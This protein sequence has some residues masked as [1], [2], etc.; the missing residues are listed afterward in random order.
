MNRIRTSVATT[1]SIATLA[2]SALS[3]GSAAADTT[4]L[5]PLEINPVCADAITSL[6]YW[7]V[8]NKNDSSVT[9]DWTAIDNGHTGSFSAVTGNSQFA[10]YYDA[11]D[12]NN[13]T[14]F[15]SEIT[16]DVQR[17]SSNTACQPG[18]IT[19]TTTPDNGSGSIGTDNGSG[20]I[21][22]DNGSGSTAPDNGSGSTRQDNGSGSTG[23]K[24]SG[25]IGNDS[26]NGS[27]APEIGSGSTALVGGMGGG[28]VASTPTQAV[29][30]TPAVSAP[31][32]AYTGAS[33]ILPYMAAMIIATFTAITTILV[34]KNVL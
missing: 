10:S 8:Y 20:S 34:R 19:L 28:P 29:V 1:A 27:T 30:V 6:T 12:P 22:S 4:G 21:G 7:N 33:R 2:A 5:L 16:D 17:N 32:L 25:S 11:T 14:N 26:T 15:K 31:Q 3:M 18:Q 13:T 24:G 23:D 9:I